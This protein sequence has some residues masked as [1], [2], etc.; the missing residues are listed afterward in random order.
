MTCQR[1]IVGCFFLVAPRASRSQ[2][3]VVVSAAITESYHVLNL[4]IVGR[5][6]LSLADMAAPPARLKNAESAL[7]SHAAALLVDEG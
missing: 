7:F 3:V 1:Y 2:I 4:V 5:P 6:E